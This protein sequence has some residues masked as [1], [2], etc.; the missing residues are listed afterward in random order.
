[1]R[2]TVNFYNE[3]DWESVNFSMGKLSV[4]TDEVEKNHDY[5]SELSK[6]FSPK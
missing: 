2:R 1:M 4:N 6:Y 5:G 3:V